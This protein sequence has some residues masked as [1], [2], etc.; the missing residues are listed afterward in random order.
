MRSINLSFKTTVEKASNLKN[1]LK[2]VLVF[3]GDPGQIAVFKLL[4]CLV[5][6]CRVNRHS[7]RPFKRRLTPRL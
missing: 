7:K 1:Y 5:G 4:V 6:V 3:L 2:V